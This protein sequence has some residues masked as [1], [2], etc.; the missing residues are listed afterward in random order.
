MFGYFYH[1]NNRAGVGQVTGI[2]P[3]Q[4][5]TVQY[6]STVQYSTAEGHVTMSIVVTA[7]LLTMGSS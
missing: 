3:V 4:Y 2:A 5:I 7:E 1:S 6:Y